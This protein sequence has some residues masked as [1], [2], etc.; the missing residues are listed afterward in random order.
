MKARGLKVM[1]LLLGRSR[2]DEVILAI[3][4]SVREPREGYLP[5]TLRNGVRESGI[6]SN[7]IGNS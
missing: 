2:D 3:A 4:V 5:G 7:C 6:L 1:T